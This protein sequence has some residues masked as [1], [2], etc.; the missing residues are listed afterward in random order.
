M[1]LD[2]LKLYLLQQSTI[3]FIGRCSSNYMCNT[4]VFT[5]LVED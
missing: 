1:W 2:H 4:I 3:D 5:K